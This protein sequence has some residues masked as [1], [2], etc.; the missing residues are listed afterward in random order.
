MRYVPL[1]EVVSEAIAVVGAGQDD[2]VLKALARQWCWRA[3]I[4]LPVTEDNMKVCRIDVKNLIMAKPKDMRRFAEIALYDEAGCYIPHIF[5]S[6]KKRI[7][8]DARIFP[9]AVNDENNPVVVPADLSEDPY[10]FYLGTNGSTVAYGMV[11]YYAYPV[12]KDD[13]PLIPEEA[14][15][16]CVYFVRFSAS[17]RKNENRS[18]IQQNELLYKQE[19]DRV[20]ARYKSSHTDNQ[21]TIGMLF[22]R[23][24]PNFSRSEF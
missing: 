17:L 3:I 7:Y 21:K 12:D 1:N 4:D 23:M 13:M 2:E 6:G 14:V 15:Q 9:S 24:I 18:E 22:N 11:R 8:P 5:H 19:A 20:R 16:M 10:A